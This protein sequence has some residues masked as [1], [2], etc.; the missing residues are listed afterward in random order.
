MGRCPPV[1]ERGEERGPHM[2]TRPLPPLGTPGNPT[3]MGPGLDHSP[4]EKHRQTAWARNAHHGLPRAESALDGHTAKLA[5]LVESP[6]RRAV[7]AMEMRGG[8]FDQA[9]HVIAIQ[10][11]IPD[12]CT[13][14]STFYLVQ[15]TLILFPIAARCF[16]I[17][18]RG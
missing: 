6:D 2:P 12:C 7:S 8:R 11:S 16:A 17:R 13:Q 3:T 1:T 14:R 15:R 5:P 18:T 10:C 9:G 4:S